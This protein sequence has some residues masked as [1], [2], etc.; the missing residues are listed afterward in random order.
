MLIVEEWPLSRLKEYAKNPRDNEPHVG[1]MVAAITEFGFRIPVVAKSDGTIIDGH[2]RFR[3]ACELGLKTIPVALADELTDQQVQAFRILANKSVSWSDWNHDLL[4]QELGEIH[5]SGY[6]LDLTGFTLEEVDVLVH[7]FEDPTSEPAETQAA[8]SICK[9][10]S[11]GHEFKPTR[12][13]SNGRRR[14]K[15]GRDL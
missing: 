12:K 14:R 15:T 5:E 3:A 2:L 9:C 1:R 10:P 4:V 13:N 8:D 11:C 6:P 7:G